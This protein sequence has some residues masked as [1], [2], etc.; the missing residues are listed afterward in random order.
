MFG[1]RLSSAGL[2]VF[3]LLLSSAPSGSAASQEPSAKSAD[4]YDSKVRPILA[5][6]CYPCHTA[7]H[8]SGLRVDSRD[9]LVR[10]GSRGPAIMP[11]NA[12]KSLLIKAIRQ[13]DPG[14]KM[15]LGGNKLDDAAINDI[16]A[17]INAGAV[18]ALPAATTPAPAGSPAATDFFE[19]KVR[20]IF[21][22]NCYTCHTN[23][24]SG[25]LRVDSRE[26]LLKGGGSGPAIVPGDP[27]KSLLIKAVRQTDPHLQMPMG[28]KLKDAEI[29]DLATWVKAGAVWPTSGKVVANGKYV[30]SPEQKN[31]WSF[32]PLKKVTVPEV[33]DTAWAKTDIDKFI[34]AKLE[35]QNLKP[36]N[37]ASKLEL[38][39]RATLDLIGVPPSG[40]EI[41][42]F[43]KDESPEAFAKVVDRLLA[44]QHYGEHS[45][46]MWLDVARYGEDD[47]RSLDPMH[48]GYNPY[49]YAYIFRDW[50]VRA[51]NDDMPYD[52]FVKAQLAGDLMEEKDR[53]HTLPGTGFLGLGPWYYD[54][55]AVE[56]TRA[57]ER[58]DRV[59][60]VS[61][62]F[63]GLTVGCARCHDHKYDPIPSA[64][65][66][67]L[68]GVFAS[69][70]YHEYPTAPSAAV[71]QLM[72]YTKELENKQKLVASIQ[73]NETSDMAQ[74]LA[75]QAAKYM[76]AA[77]RV[78][79]KPKEEL[80][81]VVEEDKLDYELLDRWVKFLAKPPKFYPYLKDWQAMIARGGT[82][83]EAK[84][85]AG[86]FQQKLTSVMFAKSELREENEIIAA[87][88][89]T[90]TTKPKRANKP[91]EFITNDDF[92]PGCSLQL[93]TLPLDDMN[94]WTDVFQRELS[95]DDETVQ[96][97]V[98][99]K[100]G[101]LAFRGW[102]LQKRL[103]SEKRDYIEALNKDISEL[104][105]KTEVSYPYLHGVEEAA[106]PVDL[107]VSLRGSP[108]NLGD[109]APRHFLSVLSGDSPSPFKGGSGRLE[110]AEDIVKQPLAMRVIVNRI[111]K[112]HF[113]TGLVDTPSNF[114]VTGERPTNPD[115]LEYLSAKFQS[116]GM[117]IKKLT[118]EIMLSNVYQLS[119]EMDEHDF[120]VD[121]GD[122]LY[123]RANKR[124]MTAEQLRDSVLMVAGNLDDSLGGPS[125]DLTPAYTRRT[126]Y[127]RVSRY[128]LDE[129]LQLFDFPPPNI[130]AEKRFTTTVPL[131]RLFLMNSDFIQAQSELLVK[132]VEDA[133]DTSAKIR[134]LY[135]LVY[136]RD[137]SGKEVELGLHYIQSEPMQEYL[138]QKAAAA[139]EAEKA[140]RADVGKDKRAALKN[141]ALSG[142]NAD[143]APGGADKVIPAAGGPATEAEMGEGMM[144]GVKNSA[145][146]P[147]LA[148]NAPKEVKYKPTALGRYAKVLLSSS[149]FVYID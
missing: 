64:D 94:L 13:V 140:A 144:A 114:G 45:G 149:E 129:Y 130:S 141:V 63:L 124:R 116:G 56:V 14:L 59:D 15:P 87:K 22:T 91:N 109:V 24:A 143:G 84:K 71:E 99:S 106:K 16:A 70:A 135:Q 26:A 60:A 65:Y 58:H 53:A 127:G 112:E 2:A 120:A 28:G 80:A 67:S 8:L 97:N 86:A 38:I 134:K 62:G 34:L 75:L 98:H 17:W 1:F 90:G 108:Y 42:A 23:S 6:N 105:K 77:W 49:P 125:K 66:Y 137:P 82:P 100:P 18:W 57:D 118:R 51:F 11:G 37:R 69:T 25:G 32:V 139:V 93:K 123:W 12:D 50:V 113:G 74:S 133:G 44:S 31:F 41:A 33:K 126:I 55:G 30:I 146:R 76:Q 68:A 107:Q 48:R 131:Q 147:D 138:E 136:G 92:C 95:N 3:S 128:R 47:Y 61:K 122:R 104:K 9:A 85:L 148:G 5:A 73:T 101:L 145:E 121:S 20:P 111:W 78:A 83:E 79:G 21:A 43:E 29:A 7:S 19:A 52:T 88:S 142:P 4:F 117:S 119:A 132:R 81:A 10:G 89:F 72:Q 40:D 102:S 46:R 39:R 54:N 27:E 96:F 110:L 36:V 103:G 35:S 115:L